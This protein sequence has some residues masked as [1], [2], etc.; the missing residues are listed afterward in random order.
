MLGYYIQDIRD[1]KWADRLHS[2]KD[3]DIYTIAFGYKTY[4]S[5]LQYINPDYWYDPRDKNELLDVGETI[6]DK[7]CDD[8]DSY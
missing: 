8:D 6:V 1:K 5:H 3:T 7:V 4:K 2:I